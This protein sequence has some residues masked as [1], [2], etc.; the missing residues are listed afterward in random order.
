MV[1]AQNQ[2]VGTSMM[3]RNYPLFFVFYF[4]AQAF[5]LALKECGFI[6]DPDFRNLKHADGPQH[7]G[8]KLDIIRPDQLGRELDKV[9][10]FGPQP[11]RQ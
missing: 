10:T 1:I 7:T 9:T 4:L 3:L 6:Q 8:Q 5:V 11:K 2:T